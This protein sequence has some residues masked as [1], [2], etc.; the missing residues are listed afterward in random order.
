M[1][2]QHTSIFI[3]QKQTYRRVL[4]GIIQQ[5]VPSRSNGDPLQQRLP[6]LPHTARAHAAIV[7]EDVG[8]EKTAA[9][10]Y[11]LTMIQ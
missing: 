6:P 11:G 3:Q 9:R 5:T 8:D 10:P 1:S 4:H 7:A 2:F